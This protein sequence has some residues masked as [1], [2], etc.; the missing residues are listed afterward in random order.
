MTDVTK[1]RTKKSSKVE[2]APT[3][4]ERRKNADRSASTRKQILEATVR[5]LDA[6]GYGS[7]T[8]IRVADEAGVSRGAMMHHFPTRQALIMATVE[9]ANSKLTEFRSKEIEQLP[10]GLAR[11]R[12]FIDLALIT[13]RMPEGM[14]CN[15][16]R[17]GSRSDPEIR[18][19][20][21]PI[22]SQI[23]DDYGR[24][25]ARLAR[26]AGLTA[27]REVQGLTSIT[28]MSTRALAINTFTYPRGNIE[29]N[30]LWMIRSIRED[31]IARQ[32]GEKFAERPAPLPETRSLPKQPDRSE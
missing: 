21:T 3:K 27:N 15:E 23:S 5:C 13:Q 30:T 26:A 10:E 7:V 14:A 29:E 17:I 18:A 4:S 24:T 11:Y 12:A 19:A 1:S 28:V 32:L 31:I 22:M 6:W 20:V 25:I 8:N 2:T 9:F 16:V